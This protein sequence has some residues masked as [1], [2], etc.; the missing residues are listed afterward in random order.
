M[1]DLKIKINETPAKYINTF[2]II[3]LLT[4]KSLTELLSVLKPPVDSV[5]REWLNALNI[6]KPEKYNNIVS[7]IVSEM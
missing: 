7:K 1:I 6:V 5:V 2:N 3:L 4:E